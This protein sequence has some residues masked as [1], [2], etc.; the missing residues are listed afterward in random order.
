MK[1]I[2]KY[3]IEVKEFQTIIIPKGAKILSIQH[4]MTRLDPSQIVVWALGDTNE[5]DEAKEL[6][7]FGTGEWVDNDNLNHLATVQK[8]GYV[9]HIFET[10]TA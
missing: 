3:P 7:L 9:W 1:R 5:E 6:Y 8:D 10:R 4:Q 2:L